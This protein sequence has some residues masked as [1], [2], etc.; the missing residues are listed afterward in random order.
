MITKRWLIPVEMMLRNLS[1][2]QKKAAET[3]QWRMAP[4]E[5]RTVD[6]LKTLSRRIV[7]YVSTLGAIE[8]VLKKGDAT[9]RVL[10]EAASTFK[11]SLVKETDQGEEV[12]D[13][14]RL[15]SDSDM[16]PII[17]LVDTIIYNAMESR[18]SDI[19]IET[20]ERDVSV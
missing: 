8:V 10:Q 7:P 17:K 14:D 2:A 13:L 4:D 6:E 15:A 12:L 18:S 1:A 3:L 19:H 9:Q 11:I 5:Y 16:S 20:R